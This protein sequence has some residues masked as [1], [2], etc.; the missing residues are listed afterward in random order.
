MHTD[1][2]LLF[3]SYP[4]SISSD[5]IEVPSVGLEEP[6]VLNN[7]ISLQWEKYEGLYFSHYEIVLKNFI[8]GYG[9]MYQ[10]ESLI[11]ISDI[12]T[13]NF[14]DEAPPLMKNPVYEIRVYNKF[15]KKNYYNP[16]VAINSRAANY[17]PERV[18]DLQNVFNFTPS[19]DETVV[20]LHGGRESMYD[21]YIIRYNYLTR[22]VEAVSNTKVLPN[23]NYRNGLKVINSSI[24][25]ELMYYHY[26]GISIFDPETLQYKYDLKLNEASSLEDFLYLGNDRFLLLDYRY[27]YT[28]SRDFSNLTLIDKQ[29]H[30]IQD[31]SSYPYHVLQSDNDQIIIGNRNMGQ[32]IAF[33]IG[34]TGNLVDKSTV[35]IPITAIQHGET[36]V[37]SKD[38]TIINFKE[39]RI[40]NLTD[41]ALRSFEQPYFPVALN[42]DGTKI[43]GTNNN[44]DWNI[45][46]ESL[47]EKKVRILDLNGS[48]LSIRDTEGYPHYLFE[49]HLGQIV[50]LSTYFKRSNTYY[51]YDRSDFF[52]EI[53]GQ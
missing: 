40:Y 20:F 37:N 47:H 8:D 13:T 32:S 27:A 18:I 2:G 14:I 39:N 52:M 21:S 1:R 9:Y 22:Q 44:P 16:Q 51:T 30:F 12:N 38:G 48:N 35:D 4:V 5:F 43:I 19:P 46:P 42:A 33:S 49:N 3:T 17:L 25:Q 26:N 50:S 53:V 29:K 6:V 10:E 23:G 24:G 7:T 36:V 34:A 11:K 41:A 45:E 15:G 28:V 31:H